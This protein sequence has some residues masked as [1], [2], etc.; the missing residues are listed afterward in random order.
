MRQK[1]IYHI[2]C[3]LAVFLSVV[4]TSQIV[5][6]GTADKR[7]HFERI[8]TF[9][10]YLNSSVEEQTVAEIVDVSQD[11]RML[12]YTDS[13]G[14]RAGFVNIDNPSNPQAAGVVNLTGRPTSVAVV[15]PYALVV[16]NTSPDFVNP[17]GHVIVIDIKSRAIITT[18]DM[19]GQP[20]SIA[21]SPDKQYAAVAIE[22]ERDEDLGDGSIP[23]LPGGFLQIIDLIGEPPSWATRKIDLTGL[24]DIAP[25][26]PEPEF[27]DINSNNIAAIT[28]QENNHIVLVDLPSGK[29]INHFSAGISDLINI[30]TLENGI[31]DL[32]RSLFAVPREPDG[33]AW[34]SH[35]RLV[36]ANEGD[37][38]GGS[39]GFTIFNDRGSEIF[40]AGTDYEYLGVSYGH[41]PEN[42]AENKGTE[43]E[44]AEVGY[45]GVDNYIF[46]ASERGSYIAVYK[47]RGGAPKLIQALPSGVGPEGLKAIPERNLF[48]AASE[49]DDQDEGVRSTISIYKYVYGLISYPTIISANNDNDLPIGWGALSAL[50]AD[51]SDPDIVY[52]VHDNYYNDSRIYTV[53]VS[54]TPAVIID[55]LVL[56]KDGQPV[57]YDLEGIVQQQDRSFWVVSEGSGNAD[58]NDKELNLLVRVSY[59]GTVLEEITLPESVNALQRNNGFEGVTAVGSGASEK[60]YVAFQR[61]WD[62]DPEN[63]VRIGEYQPYSGIWRFFYYP[64]DIPLSPAGGWVGLSEIT[65]LDDTTFAVIERDNQGGPDARIKKIYTFSIAGLTPQP[66][67]GTF[68]IVSKSLAYDILPD[69]QAPNGWV[70]EKVEGLTI[71]QDGEVYLVTDNDGVDNSSGETQF[72][73]PGNR[74]DLGF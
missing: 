55:E 66:Q 4:L 14:K 54:D 27:V 16:V 68:P 69:L 62:N 57:N 29:I 26:D 17:S 60:V 19:E 33:V 64:L 59:D 40:D 28:L 58:D 13:E 72:L 73:R 9:P 71:A 50:A 6:A 39:R 47:D 52:T 41:F 74:L 35:R 43:P 70:L 1:L 63:M 32:T 23:Q 65:T 15:G 61:E 11:G 18:I 10:V 46:V 49:T 36:T 12:I 53:D 3:T 31:I 30:D 44:G 56:M 5:M 21:V 8:A 42:R 45:F 7:R 34:I 67:G 24:A 2:T 38:Q 25:L 22:N 48:V 37:Y 20:D 51:I